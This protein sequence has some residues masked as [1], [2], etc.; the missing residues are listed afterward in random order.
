MVPDELREEPPPEDHVEVGDLDETDRAIAQ[1]LVDGSQCPAGIGHVLEEHEQKEGVVW[2]ALE[3]P[4][5]VAGVP[6]RDTEAVREAV[7]DRRV[8]V[9]Q[10]E[11][12]HVE[13]SE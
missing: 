10:A 9:F 2:R 4:V 7:R 12:C 6:T 8:S 1:A 13:R 5:D 3:R 11:G